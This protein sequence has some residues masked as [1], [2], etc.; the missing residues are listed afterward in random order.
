MVSLTSAI[1][2]RPDV[3][4]RA[5]WIY[6]RA[7]G[8]HAESSSETVTALVDAWDTAFGE[9]AVTIKQLRRLLKREGA[10]DSTT[11]KSLRVESKE[12]GFLKITGYGG[13]MKQS[14]ARRD[15][16]RERKRCRIDGIE[17][18]TGGGVFVKVEKI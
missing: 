7:H 13:S 8:E 14:M 1:A 4:R 18:S 6:A 17:R 2:A 3:Q 15:S 9:R 10:F 11:F 16:E 12:L 5:L